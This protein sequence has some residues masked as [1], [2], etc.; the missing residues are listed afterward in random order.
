MAVEFKKPVLSLSELD[1]AVMIEAYGCSFD[2]K[3][4]KTF[5]FSYGE[6]VLILA[7]LARKML[8]LSG[9]DLGN[10][11][12]RAERLGLSTGTRD[13]KEERRRAKKDMNKAQFASFTQRLDKEE[14]FVKDLDTRFDGPAWAAVNELT[15]IL[16]RRAMALHRA[17]LVTFN[18]GNL[19]ADEAE[20]RDKLQ[21][22]TGEAPMEGSVALTE[23]GARCVSTQRFPKL[24]KRQRG[25]AHQFDYDVELP[26]R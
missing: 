24:K 18:I 10:N 11:P 7:A 21:G 6:C 8:N 1:R 14:T 19:G 9:I 5:K 22:G 23:K 13:F 25:D 12:Q 16:S 17:G 3:L 20:Q 26:Q 2:D 15:E 4:A